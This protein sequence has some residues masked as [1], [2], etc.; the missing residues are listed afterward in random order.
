VAG[1][2]WPVTEYRIPRS[3]L[4]YCLAAALPRYY[5]PKITVMIYTT[6]RKRLGISKA[7]LEGRTVH[8]LLLKLAVSC[9]TDVSEILFEKD[10]TVRNH[11]VLTLN[12]DIVD[13]RKTR[14]AKVRA[15][16]ILHVFPP[17]SGG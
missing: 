11:F 2:Q 1:N 6:L 8:D 14:K 7:E 15:G 16:D 9:K 17:I 12:S 4:S 3:A 5:M 13:N 10:G